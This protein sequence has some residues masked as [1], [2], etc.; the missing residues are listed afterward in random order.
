[1]LGTITLAERSLVQIFQMGYRLTM[2]ARLNF[3]LAQLRV[4][5]ASLREL[6]AHTQLKLFARLLRLQMLVILVFGTLLLMLAEPRN[7]QMPQL[8]LLLTMDAILI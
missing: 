5:D 7:A 4:K 2:L 8:E 3:P 1:M 6:A